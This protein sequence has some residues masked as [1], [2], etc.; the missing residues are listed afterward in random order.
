[1][2]IIQTAVG[3]NQVPLTGYLQDFTQDGGIR[4]IRPTV[5]IC[6]GGAYR[7]LSERERDPVALYF[8]SLGYNV[9]ILDYSVK[10][11]ASGLNPLMEA[12][13]AFIKIREHAVEWMCDPYHVAILGFSAGGHVAASL[14]ILH[15]H[16]RLKAIFDTKEGL[17]RPDVAILCYPVITTGELGHQESIDWVTGKNEEDKELFCLEKQV[18]ESTVP[19]FIWHTVTDPSVPV[20]NS[21]QLASALQTYKIPYELHLFAQGGHG[22]SMCNQEVGTPNQAC[23]QWVGLC[24]T[25]L[26]DQFDYTL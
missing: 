4:N 20:E 6:P 11:D 23:Q 26:N 22:L 7:F 12:S 15:D 5:V 9:F 14:A 21:L 10:E 16:P 19:C 8:L 24:T 2:K 13:E 18:S 1:M 17:N 3:K 25:W